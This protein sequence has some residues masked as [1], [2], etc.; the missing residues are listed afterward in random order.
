MMKTLTVQVASLAD[1]AS[2]PAAGS[3]TKPLPIDVA[4]GDLFGRPSA[5]PRPFAQDPEVISGV[6][7]L[8]QR[9]QAHQG[10][11]EV[12][13][14]GKTSAHGAPHAPGLSK[15]GQAP[16]VDL[17][18][19]KL[20]R[21][22]GAPRDQALHHIKAYQEDEAFTVGAGA[23]FRVAAH[24]LGML[25]K[26]NRSAQHEMEDFITSRQLTKCNAAQE[27]L[28]LALIVDRMVREPGLPIVNMPA[29]EVI[30]RK[31]YGLIKAFEGVKQ[32]SDWKRP[33]GQQGQ[34]WKSR[35]RWDLLQEFDVAS[36][37]QTEW[38]IE[39]ADDEISS[40][41]KRR[42]LMAKHLDTLGPS[43][44]DTE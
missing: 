6:D 38:E 1:Q 10:L 33:Q 15:S 11:V 18:V 4:V 40:K 3:P 14:G 20:E 21:M 2:K 22:A 5:G 37:A 36:L 17:M 9:L 42:A 44:R 27:L 34:K 16:A 30:M 26:N 12:D 8:M 23:K 41:L 29:V 25:F 31:M 35:V 19:S 7:R 39:E 43:V 24:M 32:E 13:A 28:L